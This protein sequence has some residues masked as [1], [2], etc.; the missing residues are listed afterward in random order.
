MMWN[1]RFATETSV[2]NRE[3]HP[4]YR[5]YFGKDTKQIPTVYRVRY[6]NSTN[7]L[8]GII[9]AGKTTKKIF[10]TAPP[11]EPYKNV[12]LLMAETR[13]PL[14]KGM[15]KA[16]PSAKKHFKL[17]SKWVDGFAVMESRGNLEK[18]KTQREFF[19]RPIIKPTPWQSSKKVA[20]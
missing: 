4:F 20:I 6:A 5:Q 11:E 14:T 2:I 15:T 19:D 17:V 1:N 9:E 7:E 13:M 16:F 12:K 18:T 3:L 10:T 8:P